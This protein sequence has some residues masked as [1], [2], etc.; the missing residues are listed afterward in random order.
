[1]KAPVGAAFTYLHLHVDGGCADVW[2]IARSWLAGSNPAHQPK[3]SML[4]SQDG[5]AALLPQIIETDLWVRIFKCAAG[6]TSCV[7]VITRRPLR[8]CGADCGC[9]RLSWWRGRLGFRERFACGQALCLARA[10]VIVTLQYL[11]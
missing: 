3:R 7:P 2:R 5:D 9:N 11:I 8:D 10:M 1:M 4:P 6:R